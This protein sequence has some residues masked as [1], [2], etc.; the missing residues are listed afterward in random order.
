[1]CRLLFTEDGSSLVLWSRE[2]CGLCS[3][4]LHCQPWLPCEHKWLVK[5]PP[6]IL[7]VHTGDRWYTTSP[8]PPTALTSDSHTVGFLAMRSRSSSVQ[9]RHRSRRK[10]QALTALLSPRTESDPRS[11]LLGPSFPTEHV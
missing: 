6:S 3:C 8:L 5:D 10:G 9:L 1:M 4:V 11:E 7:S 2:L